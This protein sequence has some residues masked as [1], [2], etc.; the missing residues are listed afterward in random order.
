MTKGPSWSPSSSISGWPLP[1]SPSLG[2]HIDAA[3]KID[4]LNNV[5]QEKQ[6]SLALGKNDIP[7]STLEKI[8]F[9]ISKDDT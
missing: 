6:T 7:K 9:L 1:G 2:E 4:S 5:V 3:N 8:N